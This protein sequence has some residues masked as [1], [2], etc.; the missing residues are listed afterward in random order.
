ML[1]KDICI[2][3]LVASLFRSRT[4]STISVESIMRNI[5]GIKLYFGLWLRRI[6]SLIMRNISGIILYLGL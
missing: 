6:C 1:F 4:V 3:A 5:S 2:L